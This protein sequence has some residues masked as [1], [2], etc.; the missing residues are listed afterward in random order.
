[1]IQYCLLVSDSHVADHNTIVHNIS[2]IFVGGGFWVLLF[3]LFICGGWVLFFVCF[4]AFV[5]CV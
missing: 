3:C 4:F 1:M 2:R 5:F